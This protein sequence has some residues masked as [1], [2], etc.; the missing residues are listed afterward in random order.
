MN[1]SQFDLFGS[2]NCGSFAFGCPCNVAKYAVDQNQ[3]FA[4]IQSILLRKSY[5]VY[6][7]AAV[8]GLEGEHTQ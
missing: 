4:S 6:V 3:P 5:I 2:R 1:D 8:A 7:N